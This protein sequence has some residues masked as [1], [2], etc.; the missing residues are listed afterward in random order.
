[1]VPVSRTY[2]RG[3]LKRGAWVSRVA[4]GDNFNKVEVAGVVHTAAAEVARVVP[5]AAA[6]EVEVK[7]LSAARAMERASAWRV[8]EARQVA[9]KAFK[10]VDP[11]VVTGDRAVVAGDRWAEVEAVVEVEAVAEAGDVGAVAGEQ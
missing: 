11:V 3:D 9:A 5:M 6:Q 2:N 7:T 8:R 4:K 10:A 1:M